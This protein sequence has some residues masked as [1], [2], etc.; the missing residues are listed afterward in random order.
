MLTIN[1]V[2]TDSVSIARAD[3]DSGKRVLRVEA[4]SS[5]SSA[6]LKAY[7]SSTNELI[8]TLSGG[9]GEFSWPTSP[10]NITV[11]SSLGGSAAR[12]VSAK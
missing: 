10:Q 8:G 12:T 2:A 1:P 6:T 9:K 7:V 3:Y 11:R 5:S 4:S